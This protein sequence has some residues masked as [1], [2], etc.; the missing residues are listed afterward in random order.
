M[1]I[2]IY[3]KLNW[4]LQE[5]FYFEI[6]DK[7]SSMVCTSKYFNSEDLCKN[8]IYKLKDQINKSDILYSYDNNLIE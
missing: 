5:R 4:K 1:K 7:F 3:K 2:I 6:T 8:E